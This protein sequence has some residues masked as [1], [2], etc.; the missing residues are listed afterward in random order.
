MRRFLFGF[1]LLVG[2]GLSG[3]AQTTGSTVPAVNVKKLDGSTFNTS[4]LR[5]TGPTVISFWAT[6]CHPCI[7]EL[8]ALHEDMPDLLDSIPGFQVVAVSIDDAR[9]NA[10][11][12]SF[13]NGKGW[14]YLVLLDDNSDLKRAMGVNNVPHTFLVDA[15]GRIVW[16]HTSYTPGSEQELYEQARKLVQR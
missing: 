12:K 6:W 7:A 9:N 2:L 1:G 5:F 15:N 3:L 11:V 10:R 8:M 14:E 16:Q 4:E 13:V